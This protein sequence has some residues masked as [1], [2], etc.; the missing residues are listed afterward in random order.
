[1][2]KEVVLVVRRNRD[3]WLNGK[4]TKTTMN[5]CL[6]K[7][8][9]WWD[10]FF[11]FKIMDFRSKITDLA[12]STYL[13]NRF[14]QIILHSGII[15]RHDFD[16]NFNRGELY[17][18]T[19]IV[20]MDDDDWIDPCLA[21]TLRDIDT[22]KKFFVWQCFKTNA[23]N[24]YLPF[25]KGRGRGWT[26]TCTWAIVGHDEFVK[27][28][29]HLKVNEEEYGQIYFI[30]KPFTVKVEHPASVGSIRSAFRR[31]PDDYKKIMEDIVN[32]IDININVE[33]E[34]TEPFKEQQQKY[35][36]LLWKLRKSIK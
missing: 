31:Y 11:N 19:I 5:P 20:P 26:A 2:K 3:Y 15:P 9:E 27:R 29:N 21:N 18:N 22:Y 6:M 1:M 36:E 25:R 7:V 23:G 24:V 4:I 17:K 28:H 34:V 16:Q 30:D 8:L 12:S 35:L 14:D 10:S 32:R 33:L 13:K